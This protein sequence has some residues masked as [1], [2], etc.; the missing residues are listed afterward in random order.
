MCRACS[1][2]AVCASCWTRRCRAAA[3]LRFREP[4]RSHR[5]PT[6]GVCSASGT[7]WSITRTTRFDRTVGRFFADAAQDPAVVAIRRDAVSGRGALAD[8]GGADCAA[9]RRGKEVSLFVELKARF[10]EARNVGWVRRLEEAGANVVYG[11]VGLKNHA[12]VAL[13]VRR[14]GD[15]LRRYVHIGTG[16]YNAATAGSTPTSASSPPTASSA[17]DVNDLFNQLTGSSPRPAGAFRRHRGGA[18][19]TASLAARV[20]RARRPRARPRGRPA[21][22]RAKVNGVADTEVVQALYRASQAG[23]TIEL[24]VR[25]ICT[26]RPGVPGAL[27]AHPG[28]EPTRPVPGA[29]P[30]LRVRQRRRAQLLHRL[31]RLAAAESA[32]AGRGGGAGGRHGRR[33]ERLTTQTRPGAGRSRGLGA[34]RRRSYTRWRPSGRLR[35]HLHSLR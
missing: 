25:G 13:V 24:V 33:G 28:G 5:R 11:V 29:C 4:T 22:I 2:C 19:R 7:A 35:K 21:R 1:I 10:D 9:L 27:R 17:A 14:E 6:S 30:D 18:G 32:S 16:N 26:L 12:K 31:G 3:I 23:V 20:D 34:P 15:A 8:R